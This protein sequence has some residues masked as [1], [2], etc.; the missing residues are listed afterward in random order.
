MPLSQPLANLAA[1]ALEPDTPASYLANGVVSG[2][3]KLARVMALPG[4]KL[5]VMP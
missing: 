1:A 2:P 5:A 4:V 3:N